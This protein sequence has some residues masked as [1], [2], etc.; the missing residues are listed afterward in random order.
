[1]HLKMLILYFDLTLKLVIL[2]KP[3]YAFIEQFPALQELVQKHFHSKTDVS[4]SNQV[5]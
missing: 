5:H 3:I 4:R 1:M 2:M